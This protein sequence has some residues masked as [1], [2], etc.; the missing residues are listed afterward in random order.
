MYNVDL[1]GIKTIDQVNVAGQTVIVRADLNVPMDGGHV[2]DTTRLDRFAATA[3][4][5]AQAGA[6]VVVLSHFARP[7]GE[8]VPDMSLRRVAGPLAAAIGRDVEF[9]ATDWRDTA[10]LRHELNEARPGDVLLMENTRFHPGEEQ[11]DSAFAATMASL[12]TIYV[13]DAFSCAHRAHASTEGIAHHLPS[14]A[15]PSMAAEINALRAALDNPRRPVGAVV[16]GAKVSTKIPVLTN[17]L[18]RVDVLIIGGGMA[19]TFLHAQG[20]DVGKSLCEPDLAETAREIM[21]KAE[22]AG[23]K[24]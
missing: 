6:K 14:Y 24:I 22:G 18:D 13:N 5:L 4:D 9:V 16:G 12:G 23:C 3:R 21:A 1:S 17:M 19:N 10:K 2:T 7:K 11:N 15:G 8:V 20:I